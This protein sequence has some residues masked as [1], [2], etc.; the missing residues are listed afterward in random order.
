LVVFGEAW[1]PGYAI[2]ALAPASSD[3]WQAFAAEYLDQ[4]VDFSGSE[5]DAL[6]AAAGDANIDVVIGLAERDPGTQGSIYSTLAFIGRDG[7]VIDRHR[8]LR[9]NPFERAVWADGEAM[10]LQAYDRDYAKLSGLIST[11][12]QMVLP[13]YALA[14]EGTQIHAACW[15]GHLRTG[16]SAPAMWPDQLLLSRA[17][18]VQTGAYV[19]CAG[20]SLSRDSVPDKYRGL[21]AEDVDGGSSIIDPRGEIISGAADGEGLVT[22]DCS[23]AQI[24]AAKIA[25]ECA[26]HSARPDQLGFTN[27]ARQSPGAMQDDEPEDSGGGNGG[28]AGS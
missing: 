9:P 21:L 5:I 12:H 26:G 1:L 23:L 3:L 4:A 16:G 20:A 14:Q 27:H 6:A 8:K 19:V 24:R 25:F 13:A 15:P 10:S 7:Q 22:A 2:H 17:F 18:A 28:Q 11:E